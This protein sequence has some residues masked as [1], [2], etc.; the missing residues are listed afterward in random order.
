MPFGQGRECTSL[1]RS[2]SEVNAWDEDWP[3]CSLCIAR[4]A[5]CRAAAPEAV[6]RGSPRVNIARSPL[7]RAD[8]DS[9]LARSA[10]RPD[11][12]RRASEGRSAGP[13][14]IGLSARVVS[15]S[16]LALDD[17]LLGRAHHTMFLS[18]FCSLYVLSRAWFRPALQGSS[19]RLHFHNVTLAPSPVPCSAASSLFAGGT[20]LPHLF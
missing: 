13:Y 16:Q 18:V 11:M 4:V 2:L 8:C 3:R 6:A 12:P 1:S 10:A 5:R 20:F 7:A 15:G 9:T 14:I 19:A 17:A